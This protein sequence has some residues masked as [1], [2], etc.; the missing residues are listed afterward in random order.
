[1]N[2]FIQLTKVNL[3]SLFTTSNFFYDQKNNKKKIGKIILI[4]YVII[5]LGAYVYMFANMS[6]KG[7]M[8]LNIPY[9]LLVQFMVISSLSL[10]MTNLYKIKGTL[11]GFKDYDMLM[12]FPINKRIVILSKLFMLYLTNL[13]YLLMFMIPSVAV[14]IRYVNPPIVF[15]LYFFIS[16]FFIPLVPIIISTIAGTLITSISSKFKKSNLANLIIT[17]SYVAVIMYL[18]STIGSKS[19]LDLANIGESMVNIF[20]KY[21]PLSR[22]YLSIIRDNNLLSFGIF[23]LIPFILFSLFVF[24]I[25]K[26]Y[27]K[28]NSSLLKQY[29]N[30]NFKLKDSK[31]R[32]ALISLY[33]KELKRFFS[34]VNYVTNCSI[35]S[36]LLLIVCIALPFVGLEKLAA[37]INMPGMDTT[38]NQ[39][40][41]LLISTFCALS[42]TTYPSISLEGK[43]FGLLKSFPVKPITIFLSKILVN[44]TIVV[45]TVVVSSVVFT[46]LLDLSI[47]TFVFSL[48][49]PIVFSV[50][51]A[52]TGIIFN[53]LFPNFEWKNEL[54]VIKQSLASLLT[55]CVGLLFAIVPLSMFEKIKFSSNI[56]L[57]LVLLVMLM[58]CIIEYYYLNK[59]GTK[60]FNKIG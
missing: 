59:Y 47:V 45:P 14:Y 12:S 39:S 3:K 13:I 42:C 8:I 38:I 33:R 20:N 30:S 10:L 24:I 18:S 60:R 7:Y 54:R 40:I 27:V 34:S 58:L 9:V 56:Y 32:S 1:M 31:E 48:I 57:L 29:T 16:L 44:L 19:S 46:I 22:L 37:M 17:L 51:I 25:E 26:Y 50:F 6:M 35:G 11:F 23:L 15:Y 28:I 41:P 36:I 55:I 5:A 43:S 53:L 21:Y 4:F 2:D 49:I 52:L